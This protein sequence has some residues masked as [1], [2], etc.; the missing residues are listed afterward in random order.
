MVFRKDPRDVTDA[1]VK[2]LEWFLIII[3]SIAAAFASTLIAI[4]AVRKLRPEPN[5]IALIP[6]DAANY[7][8]GPL[9]AAIKAEARATVSEAMGRQG[10][11]KVMSAA[12]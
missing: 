12:E 7:L 5:S 10:P 9:L 3:P 1:E 4:T 8:F 11:S 2:T 6:D